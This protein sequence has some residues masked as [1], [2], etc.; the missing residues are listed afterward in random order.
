MKFHF[1]LFSYKNTLKIMSV[2]HNNVIYVILL[3]DAL[4]IPKPDHDVL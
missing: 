3:N 2:V 4:N 1:L